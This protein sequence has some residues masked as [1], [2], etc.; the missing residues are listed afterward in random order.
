[1]ATTKVTLC[2]CSSSWSG[3]QV[4]FWG[5][6]LGVGVWWESSLGLCR[7]EPRKDGNHCGKGNR[8]RGWEQSLCKF[9]LSYMLSCPVMSNSYSLP[10]SSANAIFQQ[11]YW[12]RLPFPIPGDLPNT[13]IQ[14][15]SPFAN[16][17]DHK[18]KAQRNKHRNSGN[19]DWRWRTKS[20][21]LERRMGDRTS[22]VPWAAGD[23]YR[24]PATSL[25]VGRKPLWLQHLQFNPGCIIRI[26]L[27]GHKLKFND[28]S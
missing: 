16:S 11:E 13:W 26:S 3:E 7:V 1:M 20:A 25:W 2:R 17:P 23:V 9:M 10:S 27:W 22:G 8:G 24:V 5:P 19:R 4:Y 12:S 14:L 6:G 18:Y 21:C 15:L 28:L